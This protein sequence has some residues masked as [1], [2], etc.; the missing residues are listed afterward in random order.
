MKNK[1]VSFWVLINIIFW[2]TCAAIVSKEVRGEGFAKIE[3]MPQE[4]S[5][6]LKIKIDD[7][8]KL[9]YSEDTARRNSASISQGGLY[10]P[11]INESHID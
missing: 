1:Y 9:L 5:P 8:M 4:V 6:E 10:I 11:A 7:W 3:N 2:V